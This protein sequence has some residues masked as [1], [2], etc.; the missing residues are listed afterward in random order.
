MTE[1]TDLNQIQARINQL[2]EE[3]NAHNHRYYVLAAPI[4][5]DFE[6]DKLL[7]ELQDLEA[8]YPELKRA[9]SPSLRV[10][11]DITK[12]FPTFTH[13]RPMLS[14]QNTYSREEVEDW[15][16]SIEKLLEGRPHTYFVQ[17]KFDGVSLSLHYENGV[18]QHGVTRGDGTQGDEITANART[19]PTV[20]LSLN[21]DNLP[22]SFEVRGE[23]LMH[24]DKFDA[25]NERR[26]EKGDAPL[27]N[28]RNA[29]AGTLKMQDSSVVASRPMTF[30]AYWLG[31]EGEI[32]ATDNDQQM[33][34]RDWGF[35]AY[36]NVRLCQNM[37]EVFDYINH[38]ETAREELP[39]E[40]D[41]IVIKV[42][43]VP[44]RE[45]LGATSKFPRWAIAFKYQAEKAETQLRFV[46]YQVGRTGTVTPVANLDPVLLAGTVVKRASLYNADELER[47]DLHEGDTV[48]VAKGGEIIPKV[49]EVITA[50]RRREALRIV[51]PQNCPSCNI[52]LQK[53]EGE[54]NYFCPNTAT[55]PPQVRG[56]I[57]HFAARR[58]MDID[59]LGTEIIAQLVEA[60]LVNDYT[61]LYDLTYEQV[62]NLERFADKS[63]R[64]LVESIAAS[65]EVPYPKVLFALG[66]RYVGETVAKKL[67]KQFQSIDELMAADK[68]AI[69][70]V[71]EIGERIADSVIAFF[72][73]A[74]N[75]AKI[76]KLRAAGVQLELAEEDKAVSQALA[77]K[78][79][80]V[81]GTLAN[82]TR[83]TIKAHIESHGGTVKG[84]VSAK[85]DYLV[86][87]TD[88]GGSKVTKAEKHKVTI[89]TEAEYLEMTA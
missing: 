46:N 75:R 60:G 55:C 63:A 83:D 41:G 79:F 51:F 26:V 70:D 61:D 47:L 54:V 64:N 43:E 17:H 1:T 2:T 22:A 85:T 68:E 81:T 82:F 65:T 50:K 6:F 88:P 20:P 59:G 4:I 35:K 48:R 27:M 66:I 36:H 10:G 73:E 57:E 84:S 62:V 5:S 72:A 31:A 42:N 18:M 21:A 3:L 7:R 44:L 32:P 78:S 13:V 37:D 69:V 38:W 14:L 39:Y 15:L 89:L 19:I 29:T 80:V 58:A 16:K 71:H 77:G 87:G 33:L 23:V 12:E 52:D 49:V 76:E 56:R 34:L 30:Y 24:R 67:A 28:P 9:D 25:L 8:A 53:N 40:I 45:I 11:G 74:D 86:T